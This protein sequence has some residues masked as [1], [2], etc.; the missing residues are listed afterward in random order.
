MR[1]FQYQ[2]ELRICHESGKLEVGLHTQACLC[3]VYIWW[4]LFE[5]LQYSLKLRF[6]SASQEDETAKQ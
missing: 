6:G 1:N 4:W 2:R 5:T 3:S